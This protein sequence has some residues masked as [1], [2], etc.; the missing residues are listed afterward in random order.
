MNSPHR[1]KEELRLLQQL[2]LD[3][4]DTVDVQLAD[5]L[6]ALLERD[7]ARAEAVVERDRRLDALELRN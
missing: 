4:T 1:L 5:A 7:V 3:M 6:N 2:L